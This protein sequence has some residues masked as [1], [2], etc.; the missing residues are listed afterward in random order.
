MLTGDVNAEPTEAI[1]SNFCEIFHLKHL[2]KDKTCFKNPTK[3]T[4]IGLLVTNRPKC[5]HNTVVIETGLSDFHKM[6]ATVMQMY[7]TEQKPS[8]VLYCM[9]KISVMI[10]L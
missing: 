5:F 8:I 2:I 4:C 9:S 7:S 10:P 1:L 3:P 6:S